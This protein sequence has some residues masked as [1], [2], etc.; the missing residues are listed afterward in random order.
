MIDKNKLIDEK[1][2]GDLV[3]V[4][5]MLRTTEGNVR[6]L[7]NRPNAKRHNQAIE[8]LAEVIEARERL[9]NK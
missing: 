8:A 4:A 1:K 6:Q 9:I 7:I 3:I 2:Y 5:K